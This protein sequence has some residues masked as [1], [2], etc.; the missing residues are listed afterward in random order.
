MDMDG[1]KRINDTWGHAEGD[2]AI[3]ALSNVLRE[4]FREDDLVVRY[5]GDEFVIL[6]TGV[7]A[8]AV[9]CILERIESKLRDFNQGHAHPWNLAASWGCV[10]TNV[11]EALS[12]ESII[13]ESDARLYEE[14]RKK[15]GQAGP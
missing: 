9:N 10:L 1:L 15:R 4:S 12:F 14:K 2:A 3:L 11:T 7:D 6:M 8:S 13:E 5:G